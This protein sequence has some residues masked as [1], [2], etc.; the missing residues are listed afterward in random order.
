MK[1]SEEEKGRVWR[2]GEYKI[3]YAERFRRAAIVPE[4]VK[5]MGPEI[6]HCYDNGL[7]AY[8]ASTLK[9]AKARLD[10][11]SKSKS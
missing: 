1:W 2:S 8:Q 11:L 9:E 6:Y 7:Y 5:A 4:S 3:V 10:K